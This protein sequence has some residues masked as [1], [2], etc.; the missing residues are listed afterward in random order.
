M[1]IGKLK[2]VVGAGMYGMLL[3]MSGEN[4]KVPT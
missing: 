2:S 1:L 4:T 3:G